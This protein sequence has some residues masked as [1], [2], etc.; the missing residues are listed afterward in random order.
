MTSSPLPAD[1]APA[2]S[3]TVS[4]SSGLSLVRLVPL[5]VIAL[6]AGLGATVL[7]ARAGEVRLIGYLRAEQSVVYAPHSGRVE[8]VQARSGESIKPRQPLIQLA[9]ESLDREISVKSREVTSL[10]ASLEQCRAKAEVEMSLQRKDVD[11]ALLRTRLE[12]AK[13]LRES[14]A[15]K[16]EHVTLR[17]LARESAN[18]RWLAASPEFL[19]QP[20]RIFDS[21][22][23]EPVAVPQEMKFSAVMR[24]ELA[25]NLAEV[26]KA[27]SEFCEHHIAE[28]EKLRKDLPEMIRK[29]AGVDVAEA[30]LA[31]ATEQLEAFNKQKSAMSVTSPGHGIVGSF[32]KRVADPVGVGEALVTVHDRE[33]PFVEVDVPSRE[34]I[35][36]HV[37]QTLRLDF[38]GEDRTGRVAF[39]CPQAHNRNG[40]AE[41][42][43]TVRVHPAGKLWPEVVIGSAVGVRMK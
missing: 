33:R 28:L 12:A 1:T 32:S 5:A 43:I 24:Q 16:F 38:A 21:I 10:Q 29:A 6:F 3:E 23:V 35:K 42:W 17:N 7:L 25:L 41:S 20:E 4:T 36:L 2:Q 26:N 30:K 19:V 13:F 11:D 39:I 27:S 34:V 40:D 15:A 31:E 37:G 18:R 14:Y 22:P 9:D 8:A